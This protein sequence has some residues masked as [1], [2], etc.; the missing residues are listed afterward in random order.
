MRVYLNIYIHVSCIYNEDKQ[1][2]T[3]KKEEKI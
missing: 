2:K 1:N 3:T